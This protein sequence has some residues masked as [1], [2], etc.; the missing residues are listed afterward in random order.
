MAKIYTKTGD[1]GTTGLLG[2][3][4][5]QKS[6]I[7]IESYGSL[8]ELNSYLGLL[9]DQK[10]LA[11]KSGEIIGIQN[12]LFV[13]GSHLAADPGGV[14]F[15]LP[16]FKPEETQKLEHSIDA[17]NETLPEMKS[18]VLPGGHQS[19]S[20]GHIARNVCRRAERN[21]VA[22]AQVEPVDPQIIV[23]LNRLSDYLFVLC[24]WM[25]QELKAEEVKWQP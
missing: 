7:R 21:V 5:R 11:A 17:M 24:R 4:R 15:Q 12:V 13:F 3:Q 20:F 19:V 10:V 22:L 16:E 9:R 2:G 25:T 18:F 23:Y 6:D 14:K 8:D 1:N